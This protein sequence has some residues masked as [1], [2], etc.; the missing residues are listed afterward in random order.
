MITL[1]YK[2]A[3]DEFCEEE[4]TK[5]KAELEGLKEQ[6]KNFDKLQKEIKKTRK[7]NEIHT[8][9][10]KMKEEENLNLI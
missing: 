1:K 5:L 7:E 4:N 3:K 9:L 2:N 6:L 8:K 10:Q